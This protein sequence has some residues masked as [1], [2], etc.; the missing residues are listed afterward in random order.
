MTQLEQRTL[1]LL[2]NACAKYI[3]NENQENINWEQRKYETAKDY[4]TA[5]MA[6]QWYEGTPQDAIVC[7]IKFAEEL[8]TRLKNN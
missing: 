4:A 3:A 1:S 8:I 7:G 6:S 5:L 2:A